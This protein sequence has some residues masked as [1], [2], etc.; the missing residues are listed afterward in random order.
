MGMGIA[1]M[2]G[3]Q[4]RR[5]GGPGGVGVEA[6]EELVEVVAAEGPVEGL[7]HGVVARLEGGEPVADLVEVAEVVGVRTLRCTIE[8]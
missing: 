1:S 6:G 8:K 4:S 3:S 7:G 5:L 2:V